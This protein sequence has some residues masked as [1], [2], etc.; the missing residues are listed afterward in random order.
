MGT[1][2]DDGYVVAGRPVPMPC[3]V[4][5]ASAGTATFEVD[6]ASV[7]K[8][9]PDAFEVAELA[10][11]R[12]LLTLAVIDYRAND[13][14]PYREVGVTF[15]VRP[16]AG[17]GSGP[18]SEGEA[19]VGTYIQRL[20]VDDGFSCEAGRSIWGFPKTVDEIDFAYEPHSVTVT[21]T[22][23]GELALTL[24]LPRGGD[25]DMPQMPMVTYT[26]IDGAPHAVGFSQGG[27]GSQVVDGGG[28]TLVLGDHPIGAELATLGLPAT[29]T[30]TTWTEN[31]QA[32]FEA[33]RPV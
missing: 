7:R 12:C 20:P 8:L 2:T 27:T 13:L 31:M 11:G 14:G 3:V 22:V 24:T 6:S 26:L 10:P 33:P 9:V 21:L 30:F 32:T 19:E 15:F 25:E 18:S 4:R 17:S 28:A 29:P 23:D 5:D 1:T 16:T